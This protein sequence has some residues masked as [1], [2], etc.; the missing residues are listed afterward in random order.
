MFPQEILNPFKSKWKLYYI[1]IQGFPLINF[2][3]FLI[4]FLEI[5]MY[6]ID[7]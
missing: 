5:K 1:R 2:F 7:F 6:S 3:L 4:T